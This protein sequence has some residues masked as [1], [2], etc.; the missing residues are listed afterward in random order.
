M[1]WA[2]GTVYEGLWDNEHRVNSP[3][4]K[5][6][7]RF[8]LKTIPEQRAFMKEFIRKH[9][10]LRKCQPNKRMEP[11]SPALMSFAAGRKA[12]VH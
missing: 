6:W 10:E 3:S 5:P 7:D 4:E 11:A 2:D 1:V 9:P 12:M 8:F